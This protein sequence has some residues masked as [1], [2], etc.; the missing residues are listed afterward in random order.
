MSLSTKAI[1]SLRAKSY[2][3][4]YL[5]A[6]AKYYAILCVIREDFAHKTSHAIVSQDTKIIVFEDLRTKH[7]T[8]APK[9]KVDEGGKFIKNGSRAKAGL[10][11]GIL[12][13]GWH[14]IENYCEY[15]AVKAGK[16]FFKVEAHHTSQEC[17]DCGHT[18]PNNRKTQ[19]EFLCVSC[20]H[21]DNADRNAALVIKKRAIKLLLDSGTEL[22]K[23]GVLLARGHRTRS[24]HKTGR[25]KILLAMGCEAS[26]M[27]DQVAL[28]A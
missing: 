12:D 10:N 17:A 19:S 14:K 3:H 11:N 27:I 16:A 22:S 15:K 20:G 25:A 24:P 7:L 1:L 9:P 23:R 21:T 6:Q 8:R 5:S 4:G 28:A 18:H 2:R 26:K 13:K